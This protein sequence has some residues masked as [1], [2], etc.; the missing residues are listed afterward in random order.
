LARY[1]RARSY[2]AIAVEAQ[3]AGG[4]GDGEEVGKIVELR[5]GLQGHVRSVVV[6]SPPGWWRLLLQTVGLE[7]VR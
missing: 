7:A 5:D 6:R 1:T 3:H 4:L 2:T